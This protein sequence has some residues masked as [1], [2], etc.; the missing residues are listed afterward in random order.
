MDIV[1]AGD[2]AKPLLGFGGQSPQGFDV[3]AKEADL[4]GHADRRTG[5]QLLDRH[6]GGSH[7]RRQFALQPR[8]QRRRVARVERVNEDLRVV[9]GP[10]LGHDREPESRAA[11]AD[12]SRIGPHLVA[13]QVFDCADDFEGLVAGSGGWASLRPDR[14]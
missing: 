5:F 4:Y 11:L 6:P 13:F 3:V 9:V 1:G 7:A 12:K 2:L 14:R 10:L 8:N